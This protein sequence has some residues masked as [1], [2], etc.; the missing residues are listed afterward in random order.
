MDLALEL[1]PMEARQTPHVRT[2]TTLNDILGTATARP[3]D[4]R[5]KK[6]FELLTDLRDKILLHRNQMASSAREEQATFSL[7]MADAG[8]DQYD[9]DFALS[10]VSADQ[11][12]IYEIDAALRRIHSG[13][14]GI[15]EM[16]GQPIEEE[17]LEA[18]PWTRF[19]LLAQRELEEKGALKSV[20][21][22]KR[23]H[24]FEPSDS[25][26]AEEEEE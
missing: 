5:W 1:F 15:C 9:C 7:H 6:H 19:S 24:L 11:D 2:K 10:M 13:T 12:T 26:D 22:A 18:L 8:T 21:F 23:S 3:I 16:S 4:R 17:R 20:V 14:Y 25:A